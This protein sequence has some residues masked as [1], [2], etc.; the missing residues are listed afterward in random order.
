MIW[1]E[2]TTFSTLSPS[3]FFIALLERF[4]L[5]LASLLLVLRLLELE[6]LLAQTDELLTIEL[7]KLNDG[8]LVNG[9]NQQESLEALLLEYLEEWRVTMDAI[10]LPVR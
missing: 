3:A 9:I 7:L 5:F 1:F 10:D 4:G 8:I 6:T 2:T